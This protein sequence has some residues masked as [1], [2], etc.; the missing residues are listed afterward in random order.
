MKPKRILLV[1][2]RR[3]Y[4][5]SEYGLG[6]QV[7]L[8]LVFLAG[9]LI[10]AGFE[11][12]LIDADAARMSAGELARE[13]SLFSPD[14]IGISH[15]GS[16]AA[17]STVK[18][19]IENLHGA[20]PDARIVYGGIYPSF[21]FRAIM[22]EVPE[23]D[24]IARG[25]GE[26]IMVGLAEAIRDGS[27]LGDIEGLVWRDD[28]GMVVNR[29]ARP[30]TDLDQYRPGWELVE[31]DRYKLLGQRASGLQFGRGCPNTCNFCGQWIFW[32]RYRH[33]SPKNFVDQIEL[34]VNKYGIEH[35]W[36]ADEHFAADRE[37]LIEVLN[38]IIERGITISLSINTSVDTVIRDRDILH[39]Y[40]K[41]GV[42]F[43]ALG[44]ESDNDDVSEAF[45][46][47]SYEMAC[48][49]MSLLRK[50]GVLTCANVI[51]G[52]EDETFKTLWRRFFRIKKMDPDFLN[53]TYLTPHFW[54]PVGAKVPIDK[55]IQ[56]DTSLWGYRNQVVDTQHLTPG[57]LFVGVKATEF[58]M[59][60][61]P[62]RI[63][64]AIFPYDK[65]V[66]RMGRRGLWRA[67]VVWMIEVVTER[68][69]RAI[70]PGE[71]RHY[72]ESVNILFP[73]KARKL[74]E[75]SSSGPE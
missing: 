14:I 56:P 44:V 58:F 33:R 59:H 54:T 61:R 9:P 20:S 27:A 48:E 60:I 68:P 42:D 66:G 24:F 8:G 52:L 28:E 2:A 29:A 41:A 64:R 70:A 47:S 39:L 49:A 18:K 40:K 74:S 35:I 16:T 36:P 57:Q 73:R 21:A 1:N 26:A 31:W 43:A 72:P 51:F 7:P 65:Q 45:G 22:R 50:E 69:R 34:L 23:V 62:S 75:E 10:D 12:K 11:V 13:S 3:G 67:F 32:K 4:T 19:S 63:W 25:E 15:T 55:I 37:A 30:I 38:D 17:H 53:A 71:F 6:Y 46:K 5:S